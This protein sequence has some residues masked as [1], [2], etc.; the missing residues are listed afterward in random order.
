MKGPWLRSAALAVAMLALAPTAQ[1]SERYDF[2]LSRF[3]TLDPTQPTA[4]L[5]GS[6][7]EAFSKDLGL[8]MHPRFAGP[9]S[10]LGSRG[11]EF[12]YQLTLSD[13]DENA[14]HWTKPVS[15]P[16]ST[17]IV[18]QMYVRKGLPFSFELGG[19]LSHL[20]DSGVWGVALELKWAMLEGQKYAPDLGI[21]SHVNTLLGSR[22][23]VMVTA[24]A[25]VVVSKAF[26]LGGLVQLVPFAGYEFT[27]VHAR[28]HVLGAFREGGL[29]PVTFILPKQNI[30]VHRGLVGLKVVGGIADF[31]FEAALGELT[32]LT[33]RAGFN[34]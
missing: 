19:V 17:L 5:D 6:G 27:Y 9:A 13:I 31:G 32:S 3:G 12:G 11:I 16:D 30:F 25:D 33:F 34:L 10:T 4:T 29:E 20:H 22:D 26:G 14:A 7:F 15:S 18:S 1:A 2:Q 8:A 24:G 23:F 28:S 21:R